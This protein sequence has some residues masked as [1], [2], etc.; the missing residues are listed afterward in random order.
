MTQPS[1]QGGAIACEIMVTDSGDLLAPG[2]VTQW[3]PYPQ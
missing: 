2:I 3:A 1:C